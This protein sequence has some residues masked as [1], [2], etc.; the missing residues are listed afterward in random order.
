MDTIAPRSSA[1]CSTFHSVFSP[2]LATM[3]ATDIPTAAQPSPYFPSPFRVAAQPEATAA[4]QP[5]AAPNLGTYKSRRS[6]LSL[7]VTGGAGRP[8]DRQPTHTQRER[9]AC[10]PAGRGLH[11]SIDELS[12]VKLQRSTEVVNADVR[13]ATVGSIP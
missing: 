1:A 8:T 5:S 10:G 6:R 9:H 13:D 12:F 4:Q 2:R 3:S 11:A 7:S